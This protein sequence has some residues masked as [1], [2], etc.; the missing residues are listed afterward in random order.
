MNFKP[1]FSIREKFSDEDKPAEDKPA[2]DKSVEDKPAEDKPTEDKSTEDKSVEKKKFPVWAIVLISI[3]GSVVFFGS[4][5][6][7]VRKMKKSSRVPT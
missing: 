6:I 4:I 3:V 5:W 1:V 2:E 7:I